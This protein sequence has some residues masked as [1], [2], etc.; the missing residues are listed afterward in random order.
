MPGIPGAALTQLVPASELASGQAAGIRNEVV[1]FLLGLVSFELKLT[2]DR[3][4]VRDI[5]AATDL[6]Y[7]TE[8]WGEVT[9]TTT[10]AYET[11]TT[12]T[13][14]TDRWI[15]IFGVK[16]AEGAGA[17]TALKFN[18]GGGDRAIWQLQ[19]LNEEDGY[20][21]FSPSPVI[22]PQNQPY[23][24]SRYVKAISSPFFC[25]LKGVV[26]EPRGKLISP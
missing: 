3:L 4:V 16:L 18:V 7:S 19:S 14:G 12:G 21:G 23:T 9:G 22:L 17:C 25:V 6:D 15:G 20:V 13:V 2:A 26:V 5:L 24:I 1:K 11:M 10:G 8:E